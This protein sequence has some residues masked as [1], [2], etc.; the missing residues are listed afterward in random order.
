MIGFL[1]TPRRLP[2]L[3][4]ASALLLAGGAAALVALG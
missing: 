1:T 4:A 3:L 2:F